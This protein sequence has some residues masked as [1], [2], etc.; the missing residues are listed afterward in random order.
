MPQLNNNKYAALAV[1]EDNEDNDTD[2]TGVEN[3][4]KITGVRNDEKITGVDSNNEI[5]ES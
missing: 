2:S 4:R 3:D 5:T 1:K